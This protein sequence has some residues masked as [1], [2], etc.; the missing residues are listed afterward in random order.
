MVSLI[1]F[2][3]IYVLPRFSFVVWQSE[4]FSRNLVIGICSRHETVYVYEN[5]IA[6]SSRHSLAVEGVQLEWI[7]S[8]W[9]LCCSDCNLCN[10]LSEPASRAL[11]IIYCHR[12][13]LSASHANHSSLRSCHDSTATDSD[14]VTIQHR[15][16]WTRIVSRLPTDFSWVILCHVPIR[17]TPIVSRLNPDP[18]RLGSCH[19][20]TRIPLASDRVTTRNWLLRAWI[21]SRLNRDF[22]RHRSCHDPVT[23][24][25]ERL[26]NTF[27]VISQ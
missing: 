18:S 1:R 14:C 24:S 23:L 20:F 8:L 27:S 2:A 6:K 16:F 9:C 15:L 22:S 19:E 26:P 4:I 12:N 13:W 11:W 5:P 3:K 10:R 7:C 25:H 17:L 21:V